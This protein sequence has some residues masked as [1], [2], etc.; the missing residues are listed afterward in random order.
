MSFEKRVGKRR[1]AGD[2]S[3]WRMTGPAAFEVRE[4]AFSLS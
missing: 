4:D 1:E 3:F 2:W